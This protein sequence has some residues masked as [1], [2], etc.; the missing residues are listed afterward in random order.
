MQTFLVRH[1]M[2]CPNGGL[3]ITRHNKICDVIIHLAKQYLPPNCVRGETLI[4]QGRRGSEKELCHRGSVPQ[5][6]GDVS[7]RGLP[8][9]QMEEMIDVRFGD[10]DAYYQNTVRMDKLL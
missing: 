2:S 3:V 8:E 4:H 9:R 6:C 1:V 5:T 7:I 10:D